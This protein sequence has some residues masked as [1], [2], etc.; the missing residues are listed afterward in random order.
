MKNSLKLICIGLMFLASCT[1]EKID[2]F[3][4]AESKSG[5][6]NV[7]KL[8][9]KNFISNLNYND[10][11]SQVL[12]EINWNLAKKLSTKDGTVWEIPLSGQ[13][14][15]ENYKQG[16]RKLVIFRGLTSKSIEGRIQEVVPEAINWQKQYFKKLNFSGRI[17]EYDLKYKFLGGSIIG[18]GKKVGEIRTMTLKDQ[19][20][21]ANQAIQNNEPN[22][23]I[24]GTQMYRTNV[25]TCYWVY[26]FY[27]DCEGDPTIS[28][29]RICKHLSY[30]LSF[31]Q[32][33]FGGGGGSANDGTDFGGGGGGGNGSTSSNNAPPPSNLPGESNDKVDPKKM[34]ECFANISNTNAMF[35]ITVY[36]IEPWPGTTFNVGPNSFGHVA[37]SLTKTNGNLSITQ[38]IGFYP[39]GVGI[40]KLYSKSQIL[41]NGDL[42]YDISG[43]YNVSGESFQKIID[44]LSKPPTDYD[45]T[46][47]NCSAFVYN[48]GLIG[49][50]P[51]P[52]PT[53]QTG[54]SGASGGGFAKTPAGMAAALREQKANDPSADINENGGRIPA[55]KG[56]CN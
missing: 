26:F 28:G 47:N 27:I 53:T 4:E 52:N 11:I 6:D 30:E 17:F 43:R 35:T 48:A 20:E 3:V 16:Y 29:Q 15:Y 25:E 51:I 39:T 8:E 55:S 34:M 45:F 18:D 23:R 14:V 36:V 19:L 21:Y 46:E 38:T 10:S 49:S 56:E 1:K 13:P 54:L 9:A 12:K 24:S 33:D 31:Y 7:T 37:I 42:K 50:V 40:Q 5:V 32:R 41:D 22:G 44:Y 2:Q